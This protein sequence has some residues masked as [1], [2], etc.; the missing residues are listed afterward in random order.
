[1]KMGWRVF[2]ATGTVWSS[3]QSHRRGSTAA[4]WAEG[5]KKIVSKKRSLDARSAMG[6]LA[7]IPINFSFWSY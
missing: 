4:M 2:Q 5:Q 3:R 6:I 7:F 1:M